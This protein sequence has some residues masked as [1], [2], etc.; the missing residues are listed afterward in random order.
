MMPIHFRHILWSFLSGSAFEIIY[1]WTLLPMTLNGNGP[2][3]PI[4]AMSRFVLHT[5]EEY[6]ISKVNAANLDSSKV[7][8]VIVDREIVS[9]VNVF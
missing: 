7:H 2:V 4:N 8:E 9:C 5:G 6:N 1:W 3:V